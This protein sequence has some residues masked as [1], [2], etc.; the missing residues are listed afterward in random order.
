MSYLS[1]QSKFDDPLSSDKALRLEEAKQL[2]QG[3]LAPKQQSQ[4]PKPEDGTCSGAPGA[5]AGNITW[6]TRWMGQKSCL[7][8]PKGAPGAQIWNELTP[9]DIQGMEKNTAKIQLNS[10]YG[11]SKQAALKKRK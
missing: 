7:W 6:V 9:S 2:A 5:R 10:A 1:P 3:V 8:S 4:C 11:E